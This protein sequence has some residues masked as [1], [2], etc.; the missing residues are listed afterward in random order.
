MRAFHTRATLVLTHRCVHFDQTRPISCASRGTRVGA[1]L[2]WK[3][4][5]KTTWFSSGHTPDTSVIRGNNLN[6]V[7]SRTRMQPK[8]KNEQVRR[9]VYRTH[10]PPPFINVT[11]TTH[12]QPRINERLPKSRP[13]I[14]A[15]TNNDP[16]NDPFT[17]K[18]EI[19][20]SARTTI[21]STDLKQ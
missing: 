12:H 20:R 15:P 1:G 21:R 8:T 13:S 5:L 7:L 11:P 2:C 16:N 17:Q 10:P 6:I 4:L 19:L 18:T 3:V 14:L 9:T